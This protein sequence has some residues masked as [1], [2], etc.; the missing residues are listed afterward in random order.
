MLFGVSL[1]SLNNYQISFNGVSI[2]ELQI[3]V[4]VLHILW[5]VC[6]KNVPTSSRIMVYNQVLGFSR[7]EIYRMETFILSA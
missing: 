5:N 7:L 1:S 3:K 6:S 2:S 4:L